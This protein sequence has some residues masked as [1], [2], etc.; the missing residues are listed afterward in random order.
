MPLHSHYW[1]FGVSQRTICY[2]ASLAHLFI[3]WTMD[4]RVHLIL[5]ICEIW[6]APWLLDSSYVFTSEQE[7]SEWMK[8]VMFLIKVISAKRAMTHVFI[9]D[10]FITSGHEK[11]YRR[12]LSSISFWNEGAMKHVYNCLESY[13]CA[14]YVFEVILN[15]CF[16]KGGFDL[17]VTWL[18]EEV[19][20]SH[21]QW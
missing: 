11:L 3:N 19:N 9:T 12:C 16:K 10:G 2:H 18:C 15:S 8:C 6:C 4:W 13:C 20:R 5:K 21:K 7:F 1:T 17:L 14:N